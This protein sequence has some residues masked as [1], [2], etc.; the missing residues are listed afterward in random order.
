MRAKSLR[1]AAVFLVLLALAFGNAAAGERLFVGR[2][3]SVLLRPHG[4]A[5][6]PDSTSSRKNADGTTTVSVSNS[7][8][9]EDSTI[10]VDESL[11]GSSDGGTITTRDS[12]GEWCRP[13][14][15]IS[16]KAILIYVNPTGGVSWS[17]LEAAGQDQLFETKRFTRIAGIQVDSFPEVKSGFASLAQLRKK[18]AAGH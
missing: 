15:P 9:C 1:S 2:V 18:L 11:L 10:Q 14:L 17:P 12:L 3:E 6:C 5:A 13:R 16:S 7:C 8:G 4:I